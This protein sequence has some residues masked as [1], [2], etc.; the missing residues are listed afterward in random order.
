M[1]AAHQG[2]DCRR[3]KNSLLRIGQRDVQEDYRGGLSVRARA[4]DL[5]VRDAADPLV[6]DQ[7]AEMF[8]DTAEAGSPTASRNSRWPWGPVSPSV[9]A[10]DL[11]PR[12]GDLRVEAN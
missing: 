12:P 7:K 9:S 4:L 11:S 1:I 6:P 2:L 5:A 3:P 10:G 8:L